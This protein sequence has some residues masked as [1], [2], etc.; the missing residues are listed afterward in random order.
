MLIDGLDATGAAFEVGY[1]SV[2]QFNREYSRMFGQPPMRDIKACAGR[3]RPRSALPEGWDKQ[4]GPGNT[5]GRRFARAFSTAH[6]NAGN[7]VDSSKLES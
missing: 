6:E 1:E 4:F 3:I 7:G 5:P 2:S